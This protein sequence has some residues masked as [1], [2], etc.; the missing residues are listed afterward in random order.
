[1]TTHFKNSNNGIANQIVMHP[2][3]LLDVKMLYVTRNMSYE[4]SCY[5]AVFVNY[6]RNV[7]LSFMND[8][9]SHRQSTIKLKIWLQ[10]ANLCRCV[11]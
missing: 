7:Y 8:L 5:V 9:V 6:Y 1:M 2:S 11:D 10:F 4:N 3:I